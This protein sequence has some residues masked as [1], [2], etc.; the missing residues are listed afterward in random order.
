MQL[1]C[2]MRRKAKAVS[3]EMKAWRCLSQSQRRYTPKYAFGSLLYPPNY[4]LAFLHRGAFSLDQGSVEEKDS[5]SS[6]GL[7]TA[8]TK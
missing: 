2:V 3:K 6:S 8:E 7:Q 4:G 1:L 5:P